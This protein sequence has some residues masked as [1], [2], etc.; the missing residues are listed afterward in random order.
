M[1][2]AKERRIITKEETSFGI[3]QFDPNIT[4]YMEY[5]Y[6][7]LDN[8]LIP[9]IVS[10]K[11]ARIAWTE[12]INNYRGKRIECNPTNMLVG[13]ATKEAAK[14]FG[15]KKWKN[16]IKNI[17]V[18]KNLINV[19]VAKNKES[20]F[21]Y[22]FP[23]G[24]LRLIT[25]GS[26][27]NQKSDNLPYIEVEEPDDAK[28]DVSGQGDSFLNLSE[29]QKTVPKTLRKFI[30]GGTPTVKDFS[31]VDK[32]VER[33]NQLVFKA[34]CHECGELVSM[35]GDCFE[36]L[37]VDEY[38]DMRI[39]EIYGKHDP[40]SARFSCPFCN[41]DW[42]F[43][44]KTANI[45][46]G[47]EF[48]F[49]DFTG[50]FS[51]GWH[52][53]FPDRTDI[54]G[55]IFSELM[56]PFE[57]GSSY[58]DI[59]KSKILADIEF[60]KGNE[61]PR[62]SF[63]NNKRG[64]SYAG[65]YSSLEAEEMISLRKNYEEKLVPYEGLLV[66]T[67][68][69]V[70]HNRFAIIK[71]AWGRNGRG[72]LVEWKEIFGNVLNW[73]DPV[74]EELTKEILNGCTHVTGAHIP[75]DST[76]IDAGDGNT[77]ELVY[78]WVKMMNEVYDKIVLATKGTRELKFSTHEIYKEPA[79]L[80]IASD[81]KERQSLASTMNVKVYQL[82]AHKCHDEILR[83]ICLNRNPEIKTDV[84]MFCETSYGGFEEQMTSCRKI[85]DG[86]GSRTKEVYKLVSGKRKEAMDA[87]KNAFHSYYHL[88]V[89]EYTDAHW[90]ELEKGIYV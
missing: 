72:F 65:G 90:E 19:G 62:K 16:F 48:G 18:L 37:S 26:I 22:S 29:R 81:L 87:T 41:A 4:P 56:S 5:V 27:S 1:E 8:P 59:M 6:E 43:A 52:P 15:S 78:R 9:T 88:R 39:D 55:F 24:D 14:T 70:Q 45:I 23:G 79:D 74:W 35:D 49:T 51:K 7:C 3:G 12:T 85:I 89:R 57:Y 86:K 76:S 60:A 38:Q 17:P 11:S 83:R 34:C 50:N 54:F 47:K 40:N 13:F 20:M 44:Q 25:L 28:D 32:A 80:E 58:V 67:G 30:F 71:T 69:D 82:G 53:K 63:Y 2:W 84:F 31:R 33:S 36:N 42:S 68:I 66:T 61:A 10:R 21:H 75:I 73:E 77:A 46:K 64:Q